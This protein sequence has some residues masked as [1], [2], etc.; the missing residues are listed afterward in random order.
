MYEEPKQRP[1]RPHERPPQRR[2]GPRPPQGRPPQRRA[3]QQRSSRPGDQQSR[4]QP[5]G[6]KKKWLWYIPLA[7]IVLFVLILILSDGGEPTSEDFEKL[8]VSIQKVVFEPS[9]L[10]GIDD[11]SVFLALENKSGKK[12][13]VDSLQFKLLDPAN[14]LLDRDPMGF[15]LIA[16]DDA[17]FHTELELKNHDVADVILFFDVPEGQTDFKLCYFDD[18]LSKRLSEQVLEK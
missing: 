3:P 15:Y 2:P 10:E 16:E 11:A 18:S 8:S 7:V 4:K 1:R 13:T 9:G 5:K 12:L 14:Q 17:G 6:S